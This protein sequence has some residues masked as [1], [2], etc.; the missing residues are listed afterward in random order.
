MN[1]IDLNWAKTKLIIKYIF[2]NTDIK[3]IICIKLEYINEEK[4][5]I[6]KQFHDFLLRGHARLNRTVK[7]I[8]RQFNWP[9]L[10]QEGIT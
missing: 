9:W 7:K 5:F 10:K 6:F 3:I 8:K 2:R 1:Q 4:L